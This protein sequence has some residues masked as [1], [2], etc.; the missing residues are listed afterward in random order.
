MYMMG[1][2]ICIEID[3]THICQ[4]I[5]HFGLD[6]ELLALPKPSSQDDVVDMHVSRPTQMLGE[7]L[8]EPKGQSGYRS[9]LLSGLIGIVKS[10][11][12]CQVMQVKYEIA[13]LVQ[14]KI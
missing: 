5:H 8:S 7:S 10:P 1:C 11:S 3:G 2:A 12:T 13:L 4:F 6:W 9:K 14:I